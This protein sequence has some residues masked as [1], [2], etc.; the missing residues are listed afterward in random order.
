MSIIIIICLAHES[1]L[2][3]YVGYFGRDSLNISASHEYLYRLYDRPCRQTG[4][5]DV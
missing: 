5:E 1:N 3:V 2:K 4:I